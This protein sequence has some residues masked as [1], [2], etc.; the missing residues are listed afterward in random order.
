MYSL[1]V[2]I[3]IIIA[4]PNQ[5]LRVVQ[6]PNYDVPVV[7]LNSENSVKDI[8]NQNNDTKTSIFEAEIYKKQGDEEEGLKMAQNGVK[9]E[10]LVIIREQT[11]QMLLK[12]IH[13]RLYS[14]HSE[15]ED[16]FPEIIL[17][18]DD[19]IPDDKLNLFKDKI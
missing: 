12:Q 19:I 9:F 15:Y 8:N 2:L 17:E 13:D 18:P 14:N 7:D 1:V 3:T 5:T 4:A 6:S 11:E 10:D 16:K